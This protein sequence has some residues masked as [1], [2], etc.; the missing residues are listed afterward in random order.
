MTL[1]QPDGSGSDV[2]VRDPD[3]PHVDTMFAQLTACAA[4]DERRRWRQ[5]I[6]TECVPL[7]DHIAVRFVGRGEPSEDLVQVARMGLVKSVDRYDPAKGRFAA[8]AVPTIRGEV[9]RHF[10]D[11]TW[12]IRVP[13]H[14]QETQLRVRDAVETLSR[15]LNR[16]PTNPELARELGIGSDDVAQSSS[17]H[18]AY[19]PLSL[20]AS[21][22]GPGGPDPT[23]LGTIHG[24]EDPHF[25]TVEDRIVLQD[26]IG[27]L[28]PRSR[29]I[30]GMRYFNGLSQREIGRRL[31]ISHVQVSRLLN[32]AL[33]LLRRR[34]TA[35]AASTASGSRTDSVPTDVAGV[36]MDFER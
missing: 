18:W 11:H 15:S 1:A 22:S 29:A 23:L 24:A 31:G 14:I 9:C 28:T 35:D 26:A 32:A 12:S 33:T 4:D 27:A 34:L 36:A 16:S 10:R 7:A 30:L 2:A 8:F 20:D 3:W 6:I 19:Q 17:A 13:R 21:R 5:R 25:E